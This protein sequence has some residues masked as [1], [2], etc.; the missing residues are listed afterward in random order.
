MSFLSLLN[1]S[2]PWKGFSNLAEALV[3][4]ERV[5]LFLFSL[6]EDY[7]DRGGDTCAMDGVVAAS[8]M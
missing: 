3:E 1:P 8:E 7:R 5:S 6:D 2:L 4:R